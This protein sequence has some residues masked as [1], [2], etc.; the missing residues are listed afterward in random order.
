MQPDAI[1]AVLI[2]GGKRARRCLAR[3]RPAPGCALLGGRTARHLIRHSGKLGRAL[4]RS[5]IAGLYV[6]DGC[7]SQAQIPVGHVPRSYRLWCTQ[8]QGYYPD[9]QNCQGGWERRASD[10]PAS[11]V[12]PPVRVIPVQPPPEGKQQ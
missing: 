9:I 7:N 3:A 10:S 6:L 5:V 11:A 1:Y 12:S 4:R 2:V 8:P